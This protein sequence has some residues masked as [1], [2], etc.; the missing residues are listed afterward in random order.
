MGLKI[1]FKSLYKSYGSS[2]QFKVIKGQP[3]QNPEQI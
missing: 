1:N 2:G 3:G